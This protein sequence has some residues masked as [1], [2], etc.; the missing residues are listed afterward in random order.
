V[1]TIWK[2]KCQELYQI[3]LQI[4]DENT[5]LTDRCKQMAE[6]AVSLMTQ[7]N[8]PPGAATPREDGKGSKDYSPGKL[9][10]SRGMNELSALER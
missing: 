2:E 9:S 1:Q 10:N 6:L 3:C 8:E 7:L 4:K 5:Y